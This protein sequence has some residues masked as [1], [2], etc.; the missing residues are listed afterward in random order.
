MSTAIT[1]L[2]R[3]AYRLLAFWATPLVRR[4]RQDRATRAHMPAFPKTIFHLPSIGAPTPDGHSLAYVELA[5]SLWVANWASHPPKGIR[6]RAGLLL[7]DAVQRAHVAER[8]LL[9]MTVDDA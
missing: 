2:A 6:R 8:R 9:E 5:R 4:S 7:H 3:R 1:N